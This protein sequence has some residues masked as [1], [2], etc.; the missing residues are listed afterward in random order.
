VIAALDLAAYAV[1]TSSI[2]VA[3]DLADDVP[4]VHADPDQLHQVLLNLV[5]NA[6]QS[7]QDQPGARHIRIESR[8]DAAAH[9][10]RVSVADNG[11]GIPPQIRAR[12]FEP[13]FTTKPVGVG[14]G[15]GLAV[16]LGIVEA[17]GGTLTVECPAEGGAVFVVT[18]PVTVSDTTVAQA[19]APVAESGSRKSVLVVDDEPEIRDMLSEILR[20]Q[21]RV[22]TASS[23]REALTR[24]G[25]QHYDVVLTDVRMPDV[26]GRAL[27]EQI[28]QRWPRLAGRVAFVTGDTLTSTLREYVKATG[29]PVLEK[30]FLP[31]DVRRMVADLAMS[32]DASGPR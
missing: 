18:I 4:T 32:E 20:E 7:L 5:I 30:P 29:C 27:Y 21:H 8:F 11:P 26:D 13:Y 12:L 28:A 17:H 25:A 9:A 2:D 22:V 23:G 15:V 14:T 3:L 10:V 19:A 6:Q 16:S 31:A 24:I 1:R